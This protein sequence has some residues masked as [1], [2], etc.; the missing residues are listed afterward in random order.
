MKT[1]AGIMV[2]SAFVNII[3]DPLFI[4]GLGPIPAFGIEGAAMATTIGRSVGV[5]YQLY[6]LFNG[7]AIIKLT[8]QNIVMGRSRYRSS[9]LS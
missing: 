9:S 2:G 5:A 4:F 8:I 1:A 7:S 3:L 6:H